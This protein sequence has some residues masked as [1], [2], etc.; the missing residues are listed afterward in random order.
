M[1]GGA[2]IFSD[3]YPAQL[4]TLLLSN[5]PNTAIW[6]IAA[7]GPDLP[8]APGL[9]N[10]AFAQ[11]AANNAALVNG[12]A[13]GGTL[14]SIQAAVPGFSGP[15]FYTTTPHMLNPRYAEWN[16]EI[17]QAFGDKHADVIRHRGAGARRGLDELGIILLVG[18]G[19]IE[20][21]PV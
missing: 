14:A 15:S 6:N 4:S 13:S 3:L 18:L 2:G 8:I 16:L 5:P 7:T 9:S 20:H 12:F 17:E 10:G 21:Q 1:R 19:E 11:A